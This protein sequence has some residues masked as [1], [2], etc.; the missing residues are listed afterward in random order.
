MWVRSLGWENPLEQEMVT[1]SDIL[2]WRVPWTEEP[3]GLQFT[4]V[5]KESD[6]TKVTQQAGWQVMVK[7]TGVGE[8]LPEFAFQFHLSTQQFFDFE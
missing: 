5:H 7:E 2:A 4:Q 6:R 8:R 3:G 1:C